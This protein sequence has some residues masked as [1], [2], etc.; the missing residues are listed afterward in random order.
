MTTDTRIAELKAA[1]A[2]AAAD[3]T[4]SR[5]R[6]SAC[7]FDQSHRDGVCAKCEAMRANDRR[8]EAE[9]N[10]TLEAAK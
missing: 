2:Q 5:N 9:W 3:W 10:A 1:L 4:F 8:I 7:P 6:R